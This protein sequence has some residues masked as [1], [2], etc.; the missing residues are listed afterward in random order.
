MDDVKVFSLGGLDEQGK[1]MSVVEINNT[2]FI[3]ECGIMF[4][5]STMPGIEYVI[6][7][8]SYLVEHKEQI[9][10]IFIT[11]AHDDV[12]R[13]LPYL[14]K[15][16]NLPIY[17]TKFTAMFL[18][19]LFEREGIKR[20]RIHEIESN[21][22]F[23]IHGID[24]RTFGVTHAVPDT[25]GVAIRS[26][27]GFIVYSGE[28]IFDYNMM[29]NEYS[30]DINELSDIG[31]KGVLLLMTES[32]NA[33]KE[34]HTAPKHMITSKLEPIF[35]GE[36]GRFIIACY[37]QSL[38]RIIEILEMCKAYK[39]RVFVR[40]KELDKTLVYLEECGYYKMPEGMKVSRSEFNNDMDDVV[41]LVTGR[42]KRLFL[43]VLTIATHE[44]DYVEFKKN[45][46]IIVTSPVVNGTE[47]EAVHME[48]EIYKEGGKIYMFKSREAASMHPSQE[49]LKMAMYLFKPKYYLP[50]KG[51][52]RHLIANAELASQMRFTPDR[53]II[54]D[55][56]QIATFK[57]RGLVSSN[58]L[59]ELEDTM[60]DGNENW[61]VT[62]VVLKDREILSTDGVM[63]IGITLDHKTH[64][65]I[66]GIDIQT[67]GLIYLKDADYL[68]KEIEKITAN[69]VG[70]EVKN[71][72]YDNL[73]C[74]GEIREKV[75]RYLSK[76]TGKR[77][78]VLPVIL[79]VN[80]A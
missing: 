56:G 32:V 47:R 79:E 49:D 13:A 76:E 43:K 14:V 73:E 34:G 80:R 20:Y 71:N 57:N 52:Y 24:I 31:E 38:F 29:D 22:R 23:K 16:I 50:I 78:M 55:N 40:D 72:T 77:P 10:G 7:D 62:G 15:Q 4:P 19:D 9:G 11:H 33:N 63:I 45:D 42:G 12:M 30:C 35:E 36:S 65:I 74:R 53:I 48:N 44:D 25:F 51:E 66:S 21:D 17:T 59:I 18:R 1:N 8:F 2:I 37:R 54:L 28:F 68:I 6:P 27:Q 58:D 61:D 41:V 70:E 69:V 60:I 5:D 3:I 26:S 75:Q 67:R 39:K 46:T 64:E